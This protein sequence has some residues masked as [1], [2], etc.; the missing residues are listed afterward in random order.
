MNQVI[1]KG[2]LGQDPELKVIKE[3][4]Q[5]ANFSIATNDG[6][7]DKPKTNWHNC[8]AWGKTAEVI[9]KFI[10]K[11]DEIMVTGSIEYQKNEETGI[12]YP[13]INV[14]R[15]EFCGG[16]TEIP[17]EIEKDELDDDLPF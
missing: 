13:K 17:E 12:T 8:S 3:G 9:N 15:F 6:T 11:G 4:L 16:R 14:H 5:V 1:L 2:R 10:G 7:K